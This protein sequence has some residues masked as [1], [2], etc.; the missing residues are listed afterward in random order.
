MPTATEALAP[1]PTRRVTMK[2]ATLDVLKDAGIRGAFWDRRVLHVP[3]PKSDGEL[4][5]MTLPRRGPLADL[6]REPERAPLI[7]RLI[8]IEAAHETYCEVERRRRG[9]A[10]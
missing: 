4:L 9:G 2:Q 3:I 10:A 7:G 5:L 6:A 8:G 1:P